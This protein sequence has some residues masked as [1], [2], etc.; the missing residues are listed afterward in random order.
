MGDFGEIAKAVKPLVDNLARLTGPLSEELGLY[1]GD[2]VRAFRHRNITTI[3]DGSV[4]RLEEVGKPVEPV[5]PRLLLPILDAASL[6]DNPTLQDMWSGLLAS[7][8]D[9]ADNMSPSYAETLKALKPIEARSVQVLYD[10]LTESG[11]PTLGSDLDVESRLIFGLGL[12]VGESIAPVLIMETLERLGLI[13]RKYDLHRNPNLESTYVFPVEP[14]HPQSQVFGAT[15]R[16]YNSASP[17]PLP[18]VIYDFAFTSYGVQFMRACQ[19]PA[20]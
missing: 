5:P 15:W 17:E 7:A 6:E 19:G 11:A 14:F 10:F 8:S 16:S 2:K 4:K 13:R 9:Q 1:F 3:V 20:P 12:A 18:E